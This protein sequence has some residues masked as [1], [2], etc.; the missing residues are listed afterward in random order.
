[1]AAARTESDHGVFKTT[2]TLDD[3]R[4]IAV[5]GGHMDGL[6]Q[7]VGEADVPAVGTRVHVRRHERAFLA[8]ELLTGSAE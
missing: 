1:V 7:R 4:E 2:L 3:G 6:V 8:Q 5:W